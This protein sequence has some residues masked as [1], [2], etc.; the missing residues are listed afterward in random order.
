MTLDHMK[1]L[2]GIFCA[3]LLLTGAAFQYGGVRLDLLTVTSSSSTVV[4]TKAHKQV[5]VATGSSNQ[6]Y[7]L[8]DATGLSVGYWYN[9]VNE[10]S[11]T[12]TVSDSS[13]TPITTLAQNASATLYVKSTATTGGPWSFAKA[14]S[15]SSGSSSVL[16]VFYLA[17][18]GASETIDVCTGTCTVYRNR[19]DEG[20]SD[21]TVVRD[22]TGSYHVTIP[23]A[24]CSVAPAC[25][26]QPREQGSNRTIDD[27]NG[28]NTTTAWYFGFRNLVASAADSKG[29][30]VCSCV[31]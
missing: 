2:A 12:L 25:S 11:G 10:S 24:R 22:S 28:D 4:L 30:I 9:F 27:A 6:V 14:I 26:I 3:F 7:K 13:S 16:R 8:P 1:K 15:A 17:F 31:K 21:Y 20:N 29:D 23:A 5:N 18:G 19:D